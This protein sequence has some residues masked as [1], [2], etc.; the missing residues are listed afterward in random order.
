MTQEILSLEEYSF[1]KVIK[2]S[3][4]NPFPPRQSCED[5]LEIYFQ[6]IFQIEP[7]PF[8]TEAPEPQMIPE[9]NRHGMLN[10][11]ISKLSALDIVGQE[12]LE[13]YLRYQYRRNFQ[14]NTIRAS[15]EMRDAVRLLS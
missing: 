8:S 1:P 7:F 6:R 4:K 13:E 14:T 11:L 3:K 10:H 12:H 15:Y 9:E 5:D 2:T